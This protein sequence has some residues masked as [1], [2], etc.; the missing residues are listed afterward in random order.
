VICRGCTLPEPVTSTVTVRSSCDSRLMIT[1]PPLDSFP[2]S[3][4][5]FLFTF[6]SSFL[7]FLGFC[8]DAFS[9]LKHLRKKN[10][11][12][13]PGDFS[14]RRKHNRPRCRGSRQLTPRIGCGDGTNLFWTVART[15][16]SCACTP[17]VRLWCLYQAG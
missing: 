15:Q 1:L 17:E 11:C 6:P 13:S 9:M 3:S 2:C 7:G 4:S 16:V 12:S 8:L 5:L 14:V 10:T